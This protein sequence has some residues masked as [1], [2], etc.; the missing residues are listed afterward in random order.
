MTNLIA[1]APRVQSAAAADNHGVTPAVAAAVI[2][3]LIDRLYDGRAIVAAVTYLADHG[4]LAGCTALMPE[5]EAAV[6]DAYVNALPAV[7]YDSDEW[8]DDGQLE[9]HPEYRGDIFE[10][11]PDEWA[12]YHQFSQEIEAKRLGMLLPISGGAPDDDERADALAYER[13]LDEL[14]ADREA[15]DR[16][17]GNPWF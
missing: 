9:P 16:M 14:A 15:E 2:N 6:T 11:T 4:E 10:P 17:T 8:D 5:D 12:A 1:I 7:D 13:F 3:E